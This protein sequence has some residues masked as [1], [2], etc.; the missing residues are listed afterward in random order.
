MS[1][2][3][4]RIIALPEGV[5]ANMNGNTITV[6]GKLGT[7][8]LDKN[9]VIKVNILENQITVENTNTE[10]RNNKKSSSLHGT[11]NANISNLVTGV[12]KGYKKEMKIIGVGYKTKLVGNA[13]ELSLGFSHPVK[14]EIPEGIKIEVKKPTEFSVSGIDKVLVGNTAAKI[15]DFKKPE[16][17]GGKGIRY[18]DEKVLRKAGKQAQ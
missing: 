8:S 5:S 15:R 18:T 9:P 13:L 1:R 6:T 14:F 4:K 3:G 12:S 16:P 2:I 7:L 17:Y 10:K 11:T